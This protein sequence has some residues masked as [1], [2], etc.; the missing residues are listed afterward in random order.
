MIGIPELCT[1]ISTIKR[2]H[3]GLLDADAK[4]GI[5]RELASQAIVTDLFRAKLDEYIEQRHTLEA[6]RREEVR[7]KKDE[8]EHLK[9]ESDVNDVVDRRSV[10]STGSNLNVTTT[11]NRVKQSVDAEDKISGA[12]SPDGNHALESRDNKLVNGTLKKSSKKQ[13]IEVKELAENVKQPSEEAYKIAQQGQRDDKMEPK[14]KSKE[15]RKESFERE[16]EKWPIQTNPL[17]KDRNYNRYWWFRRDGRLFVESSDSKQWGYY[18]AHEEVDALMGSLNCKGIRERALHAQLQNSYNR[19]CV[20]MQ[21]KLKDT[22]HK[23]AMEEAVV[24][25]STRVRAP[26]R[27]NP[28][29]AFLRYVNKWK[30]E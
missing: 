19:I 14:K 8:K 23:I 7:K 30:E 22:A 5:L 16:L 15:Q 2:G 4:L 26:P 9:P 27:D 6:T 24:R 1:H 20:E 29:E 17:G 25:R 11:G 3:Y 21:K 18:S 28:A 13:K 12:G 10:E